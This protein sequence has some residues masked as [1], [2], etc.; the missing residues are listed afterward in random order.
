MTEPTAV[1]VGAHGRGSNMSA[2]IEAGRNQESLFSIE[3]V[4]GTKS[5]SPALEL[6]QR[7][8]VSTAVVPIGEEYGPRLVEALAGV[9]WVCLAGYMRLLPLEVLRNFPNRVLNIHP[10]LLPNY[11]GKGMFGIHVHEAVIAAGEK[12]SGCTVHV[13]NEHYDEGSIVLQSRCP[14]L[15]DD[16]PESLAA[17]VLILEHQT[18]K[19]AL[20]KQIRGGRT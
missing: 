14:V 3:L 8:G 10:S 12:E 16:S 6:A 20:E 18:Y 19:K 2:L 4:V 5:T 11:G 15:D 7:L 9:T 17:R 13:V 1:L